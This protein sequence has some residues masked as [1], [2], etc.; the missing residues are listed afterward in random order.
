MARI[1]VLR[2]PEQAA[3]PMSGTPFVLIIDQAEF[4]DFLDDEGSPLDLRIAEATGARTV[5]VV[6][7]TLDVA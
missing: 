6:R 7:A 3:G 1:Q 5:L 4:D 2:L